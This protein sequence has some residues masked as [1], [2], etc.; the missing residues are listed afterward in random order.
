[1]STHPPQAVGGA[2]LHEHLCSCNPIFSTRHSNNVILP[3]IPW[4]LPITPNFA[5]HAMVT[6][7][8][9]K[10]SEGSVYTSDLHEQTVVMLDSKFNIKSSIKDSVVTE[11]QLSLFT[12]SLTHTHARTHAR[13]RAHTHTHTQQSQCLWSIGTDYTIKNIG[14]MDSKNHFECKCLS[15]SKNVQNICNTHTH[16][17]TYIYIYI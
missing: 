3:S 7:H 10:F 2:C 5:Q 9:P 8:Y 15:A 12:H 16:T 1:M 17:H 13:A 11:T 14:I 4:S 6:P